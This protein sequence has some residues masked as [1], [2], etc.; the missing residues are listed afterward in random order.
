[1][2]PIF[3]CDSLK[4]LTPAVW[5]PGATIIGFVVS[6]V[7]GGDINISRSLCGRDLARRRPAKARA[8]APL[9]ARPTP[10]QMLLHP[11]RQVT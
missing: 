9:L 1:M 11:D 2:F 10:V 5:Y 3:M 4:R 6:A 8:H 7:L